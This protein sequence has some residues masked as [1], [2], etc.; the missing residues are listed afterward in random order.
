MKTASLVLSLFWTMT[1]LVSAQVNGTVQSLSFSNSSPM[2]VFSASPNYPYD[3][4]RSTNFA[5]WVTLVTTNV[6]G[7]GIFQFTDG[8]AD[9]SGKAPLSAF[10]RL[11]SYGIS[12]LTVTGFPTTQTAGVA[13]NVTVTAKDSGGNPAIG[14]RGTVHFTSSDAQAVLPADYAFTST[15]AGVHTF[16]VTLKTAGAQSITAKDTVT[17]SITGA[18]S[19]I[20]VTAAAAVSLALTGYLNPQTAGNTNNVTITA[21]DAFG[22]TASSY[23]GTAHVT[24]SDAQ[25]VLPANYTF[26]AGDNGVH[27]L[28]VILK[29][30]GTQTITATDTVTSS[31]NGM[32]SGIVVKAANAAVMTLANYPVTQIAGVASN[33][34]VTL[35]DA[36]GNVATGYRGT[37][38]WTSS[39][40]QAALPANYTFTSGDNGVHTF[41][42]T[43]KTAG[44]QSITNTDTVNGAITA[45]QTG[46]TVNP[47]A[48]AQFAVAGFPSP[49][50]AG[51]S[52]NLT[53]TAKDA[54]GNLTPSYAGT[55]H[56][57]SSDAQ[58]VLPA[59]YAFQA[60]DNGVHTFTATLKTA[61]TDTITATDTATSSIHGTQSGITVT[62]TAPVSLTV[63]GYLNPQTAGNTNNVTV[64][65]KDVFG[66]TAPSYR[67]TVNVTSSDP[68]GVLPANYTFTAGDNGVHA[69]AVI[70]KTAGTQT[71]TAADTVNPALTNTQ[72]GIVVKAANASLVILANFPATQTAGVASNAVVTMFDAFGNVATGYRGTVHWTS[73][74]GQAGLPANYTFTAGDNGAHT[75]SVTLKTAGTQSITL[76]DTGN[77]SLTTTQSGITVNPA[78]TASLAL[79]GFPSPQTA[80]I[81]ANVTVTAKDAYGNTTPAY[82]GTV[83]F[84]SGDSQGVLPANYTFAAG[85]NGVRS[86]PLTFETAATQ[87]ITATDTVNS[88]IT[89]TQSG[90][91]IVAAPVASIT[92]A[93]FTSPE[94]A[95]VATNFTVTAKDVYGNV[96][97][98][99]RGT[100]HLTSSD[101]QAVLPANY[102]FTAGDNGAHVFSATL[103][104]AATETITAADTVTSS[105]TATQTGI[106]II[107]AAP[108]QFLLSGYPNPQDQFSNGNV[109]V[110]VLDPYGNVTPAYRGTVHFTSSDSAA[111][112]PANYTFTAGDAGVHV[113]NVVLVTAS[114]PT[115]SITATDTLN[116]SITGTE[117]GITVLANGG[118]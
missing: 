84:S 21:K 17:A 62:A 110:T 85:D 111:T 77:S 79:V 12:N 31:I 50:T 24:G 34:I 37:V 104:T 11:R 40:S 66:N 4:Q 32:Q 49:Q 87:A 69:L 22:N 45:N 56:F 42:V 112:L 106:V 71:I 16:S 59:D 39:D 107:P 41:S 86:F 82:R 63:T 98:S 114:P 46:I 5:A 19:G 80:G 89:G 103:K 100:V 53:V 18:Q 10:Y 91:T 36:F 52:S 83:H 61:G 118:S 51:V 33:A 14:Y 81:S 38:H 8:F 55:V 101:P 1:G 48:T 30:S 13:S 76:T 28:A 93:G 108:S 25:A 9:L 94:T 88:S 6:P 102:T 35:K 73:T 43:L 60:G 116:S 7:S 115:Q 54:F 57:T 20:T 2:V 64:T 26:V 72:S 70:M 74:D 68:Q 15:D 3:I 113:F 65:A 44:T 75:F 92:V 117:A 23:R 90:I 67:G 97:V 78:A 47:A 99:Y 109:T 95:G 105:L 29:T 96:A 27:A 58:A